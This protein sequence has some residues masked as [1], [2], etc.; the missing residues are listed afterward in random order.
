MAY[1][2]SVREKEDERSRL[3]EDL[4]RERKREEEERTAMILRMENEIRASISEGAQRQEAERRQVRLE[5]ENELAKERLRKL[6]PAD[7]EPRQSS[8]P[9]ITSGAN[10][11]SRQAELQQTALQEYQAKLL[12]EAQ[13]LAESLQ[14]QQAEL[15]GDIKRLHTTATAA[16]E[17]KESQSPGNE[18]SQPVQ[19]A[20]AYQ[21]FDDSEDEQGDDSEE[22]A[23]SSDQSEVSESDEETVTDSDGRH[24][25]GRIRHQGLRV[26]CSRPW[27]GPAGIVPFTFSNISPHIL[28]VYVRG[29]GKLPSAPFSQLS[30]FSCAS[31]VQI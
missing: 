11:S 8:G 21:V 31:P 29:N 12:G 9:E 10:Q 20:L 28:P 23:L 27:R 5:M 6:G 26:P 7:D 17:R 14:R 2:T 18:T 13:A 30:P 25:S 24:N 1:Q 22:G 3:R 4:L 16:D 15:Q 19:G